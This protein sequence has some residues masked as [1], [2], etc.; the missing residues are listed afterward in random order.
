MMLEEGNIRKFYVAG[1]VYAYGRLEASII[2]QIGIPTERIDPFAP[3]TPLRMDISSPE[4]LLERASYAPAL[5]MALSE[6]KHTPNLLYT[7]RDKEA[8]AR[9]ARLNRA[10]MIA[11]AILAALCVIT[12]LWLGYL[13][14]EKAARVA[15]LK[16]QLGKTRPLVTRNTVTRLAAEAMENQRIMV[17]YGKRYRAMAVVGELSRLT[18][19]NIRLLALEADLLKKADAREETPS[20]NL[21][22]EG[23]ASGESRKLEGILAT[24]LLRLEGSPLFLQPGKP[25]TEL[26]THGGKSVLHF[27]VKLAISRPLGGQAAVGKDGK[28]T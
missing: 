23:I 15:E 3:G 8:L 1:E 21:V 6:E 18:P 12:F 27:T 13:V 14:S 20:R 2:E 22:L 19:P 11:S 4:T 9:T 17:E 24:Y 25:D 7:Y 10:V 16:R 28:D 26:V 5:G